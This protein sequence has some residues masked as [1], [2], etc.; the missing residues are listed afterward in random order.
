VLH[1]LITFA[2]EEAEPSKAP[3]YIA[4]GALALWAVLVSAIG[5]RRHENWPANNGTARALM[6]I[7]A[8]LVLATMAMAVVTG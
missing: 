5:I 3:F 4:A 2:A 7:S 6:A 8:V 1:H